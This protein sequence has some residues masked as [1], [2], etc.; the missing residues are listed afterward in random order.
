VL[1]YE[2][3]VW[4]LI[5]DGGGRGMYM[6]GVRGKR[7]ELRGRSIVRFGSMEEGDDLVFEPSTSGNSSDSNGSAG[8]HGAGRVARDEPRRSQDRPTTD[9][10]AGGGGGARPKG[11][12]ETIVPAQVSGADNVTRVG[13]TGSKSGILIISIEGRVR[14]HFPS[15]RQV[16]MG[17]GRDN[18]VCL[19]A[20]SISRQHGIVSSRP[21]GAWQYTDR[22]SQGTWQGGNRITTSRLYEPVD[23]IL[24]DPVDGVLVH[25]EVVGATGAGASSA[26][27]QVSGSGRTVPKRSLLLAAGAL[28]FVVLLALVLVINPGGIS[29]FGPSRAEHASGSALAAGK[30]AAVKLVMVGSD[31]TEFGSGSGVVV[32]PD[33]TILT[34]AHVAKPWADGQ[35]YQYGTVSAIEPRVSYVLV[36]T[37]GEEDDAPV[38][39]NYRASLVAVDGYLDLAAVKINAN[40]DGTALRGPLDLSVAK[41]GDSADLRTGDAIS[42]LGFPGAAKS[43]SLTVTQGTVS[44]FAPD[45]LLKSDRGWLDTDARILHGNSGGPAIDS[46]GRVIGIATRIEQNGDDKSNR[47]RPISLAGDVLDRAKRG[48][49]TDSGGSHLP[50]VSGVSAVPNGLAILDGS[51]PCAAPGGELITQP[52]T[53][54]VNFVARGMPIDGELFL[55]LRTPDKLIV[56]PSDPET[57][58]AYYIPQWKPTENNLACAQFQVNGRAL[59]ELRPGQYD[60]ELWTDPPGQQPKSTFR[61]QIGG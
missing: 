18:D 1:R 52:G 15:N 12:A 50:D 45:S 39:V 46:R 21:D 23:L 35:G 14:Q 24:G 10:G 47:L 8:G 53:F 27:G 7:I 6:N 43:E 57:G 13:G 19:E 20:D 17:R 31:G 36:G 55:A 3:S 16:T 26:P 49:A 54:T 40:A 37:V 48:D 28:A 42:V 30:H 9:S 51:V 60:A 41:I 56:G 5:D 11:Y 4:V 25:F 38:T 33:G 59:N 22:S 29:P 34:N 61:F 44:T 32:D 58:T 2:G